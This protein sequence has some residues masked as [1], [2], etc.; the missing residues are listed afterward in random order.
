MIDLCPNS[1]WAEALEPV[2]PS[3]VSLPGCVPHTRENRQSAAS[4]RRATALSASQRGVA[5]AGRGNLA[6]SAAALVESACW[7]CILWGSVDVDRCRQAVAAVEQFAALLAEA[8]FPADK[9]PRSLWPEN[10]DARA[11]K[12]RVSFSHYYCRTLVSCS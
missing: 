3:F 1:T 2:P 9:C 12:C 10:C 8:L 7:N 6:Y 4:Q 11:R 5:A